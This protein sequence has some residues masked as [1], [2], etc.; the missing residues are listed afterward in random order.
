M[1]AGEAPVA[2]SMSFSF[3]KSVQDDTDPIISTCYSTW[4]AEEF[5]LDALIPAKT[6]YQVVKMFK[7][8]LI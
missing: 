2:L 6:E 5:A 1:N 4:Q 3:I 7:V 8:S